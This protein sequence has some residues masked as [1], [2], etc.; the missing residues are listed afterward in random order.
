MQLSNTMTMFRQWLENKI[1]IN[2][3]SRL[4]IYIVFQISDNVNFLCYQHFYCE[5]ECMIMVVALKTLAS[6]HCGLWA[7]VATSVS[8]NINF[9][10]IQN[11]IHII[12]NTTLSDY[13]DF[14]LLV[15]IS[16]VRISKYTNIFLSYI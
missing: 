11:K 15:M 13:V 10:S 1:L 4:Y 14:H 16:F 7:R 12:R 9:P 5:A 6:Y 2:F 8:R 3:A